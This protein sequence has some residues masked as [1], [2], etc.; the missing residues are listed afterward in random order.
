MGAGTGQIRLTHACEKGET[1]RFKTVSRTGFGKALGGN[2]RI[3]IKEY[4]FVRPLFT[5]YHVFQKFHACRGVAF[6]AHLV[7]V[8]RI[9]KPV[10]QHPGTAR[11]GRANH[12]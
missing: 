2:F 3:E 7:R 5:L 8:R 10:G 9:R 11:Q 12:L 4:R 6:A 1:F